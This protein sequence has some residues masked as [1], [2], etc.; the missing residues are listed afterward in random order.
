MSTSNK[1]VKS[2][3]VL[4]KDCTSKS[5]QSLKRKGNTLS[6]PEN[7]HLKKKHTTKNTTTG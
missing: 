3:Q 6:P 5:S 7:S 1:H 2:K 4:L